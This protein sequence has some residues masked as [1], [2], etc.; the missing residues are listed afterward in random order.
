M[1]SRKFLRRAAIA[2]TSLVAVIAVSAATLWQLDRA[3]PPPL[4]EKL[5]VSTEVQD[6]DG[7]L[8]RAFATPDGYWRLETRLDQVDNQF[9]DM[10]V[11]YEDK[12]FWNHEGVDVLALARAAGQFATSGHIVSGGSTLSMQLARLIE[13]R[14]SR[15][16]GSKL[17][18]MLR[19]IQ[20]ERRLSK[21]EILERYLTLAPY[22][23]NLEGVR[24]ASL[25]YFG[26]EPKR[27]T[28]SE[29]A[30]LVALP[31]LPEKRRPDR[32]LAI[33]HAARDRVLSRMASAGLLGEREAARAALDD[34]SGLRRSLPA[35]AAHAA[36]AMLPKAVPGQPLKLTIRKSVQE[37]LEQVARDAA[38]KLGAR[39]SVAMV[40]ADS[41]TGDILGEVGSANFFDASRSGWIDMTKVV[42]SPGSTLKP[43]IYG[44]AFEQGLVA[45]EMLIEDSPA[46]F[47]GYRPKNFDMGYQGDVS[48]REALQLSLN[49]PAIRVLDAVGPARLTAR[50]RQA[51]VNPILPVNEAPG[52]AI[53]LGGVGVTLRDLVQLYTGLAN[54]G[55]THTLHDGTEPADAERT[56][57]TILDDQASWQIIDILSGVKPPEGALQRGIAYKT[58]T[59]YGYRDAW[60][61]GFDGRYVLGVWVGRADA[62]AVPGLSG[63]VSAAPILFE[64]FVR[65]GLATVPL[66]GKPPGAFT[67]RRNDLPVTL[68]RFGAGSDGLVQASTPTEPAPTII[69]PPDGAR[70]DL[71]TNSADASPLVLKLQGGRAPFRWLANGKPLTGIDRRRTAT[72]Q[73]D[74]T[75]Y[76]TLTVIDAA[77]RAASVKVF[78]E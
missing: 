7:Q 46:D 22:G 17:K 31:Q 30:L 12:R 19:A 5:T 61:V 39:L 69:F 28:V 56:T 72:W 71:A 53:G 57:A 60:S 37:G 25:A 36:Y 32:N 54:G 10:L 15:S 9:V 3:F 43:F 47:G 27:L 48:I 73:P 33:A 1:P 74:G 26:K 77:G 41:R 59:S 76:S 70:V 62:G 34:V 23:G 52:L 8:L 4:P 67:P 13:P 66:P 16:L 44:L 6:R 51:G 14:D 49:V 18:Q 78:V 42:R 21:H 50:F 45:Q 68:A 65:S 20:I 64:G 35:L 63:Y 24:A 55:K 2:S 38:A 29:A 58:G 75:G 40:L 11:T